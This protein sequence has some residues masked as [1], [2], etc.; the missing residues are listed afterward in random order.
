VRL[1]SQRGAD[2][3]DEVGGQLGQRA[4]D[5]GAAAGEGVGVSCTDQADEPRACGPGH[6]G[7]APGVADEDDLVTG[8]AGGD[9]PRHKLHGLAVPRAPTVDRREPL[10]QSVPLAELADEQHARAAAQQNRDAGR[11]EALDRGDDVGEHLAAPHPSRLLRLEAARHLRQ[12]RVAGSELIQLG[13]ELGP[14]R[15]E[16]LPGRLGP[17]EAQ[18]V[19]EQPDGQVGEEAHRVGDR[20]VEVESDGA[21]A[22]VLGARPGGPP[23]P[24]ESHHDDPGGEQPHRR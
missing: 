1:S 22:R 6:V 3:L 2:G 12:P 18:L 5:L 13:R 20:A 11:G 24:V 7:V 21:H 10:E 23:R 19:D 16:V 4:H 14:G 17:L 9:D 8:E 15:G